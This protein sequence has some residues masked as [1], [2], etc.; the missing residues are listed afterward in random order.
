MKKWNLLYKDTYSSLDDIFA[1]LLANRGL[2]KKTEIESFLFP[3]LSKITQKSVGIDLDQLQI[4]VKRIKKAIKSNEKIIVYGDY[5]VDGITG[6]AILW[7]SL[8]KNYKNVF[9]YI[10]DRFGEGYGLSRK[11]IDHLLTKY[12][13]TKIIVT[14]DNGIVAYEAAKYA[15]ELGIDVIITDHHVAGDQKLECYALVH[16]TRLCGAAVGYMLALALEEKDSIDSDQFLDLVT[17][18]T[19]ADLVPLTGANRALVKAG[20]PVLANTKRPGLQALFSVASISREKFGIYEIGH[21]I[22]PRLN[23]AGRLFSA[24]DSLRLVCTKDFSKASLLAANLDKTN[25]ERQVLTEQ[26]TTQAQVLS[27][28]LNGSRIVFVSHEEFNEGV[29]GLVASR[30]VE[31]YYRPSFVIS[32]GEK[33]SKGS[34]RSVSGVNIIEMIR[35]VSHTLVQAGGHPMAAGFTVETA[36]LAEFKEALHKHALDVILE[37]QLQR[38]YSIDLELQFRD[39][40]VEL[41]EK[42]QLLAPFGMKNSEPV[43]MSKGVTIED[44]RFVGKNSDHVKLMLSQTGKGDHIHKL[45]CIAFGMGQK[46]RDMV[47]GNTLDIIYSIDRDEWQGR[48]RMQLKI[49]DIKIEH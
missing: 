13:D 7:E 39:I 22:A 47:P 45:G 3:D 49:K 14:V 34:A 33:I 30:L 9:P 4:A 5:D 24:M 43:F 35:S 37:E 2:T 48:K 16:T 18:A 19:V 10:P 36:R 40:N 11:G 29:I 17:L 41:Y 21:L 1:I 6:T 23:A 26:F 15:K 12:P 42:I 44:L 20:L 25:R 38:N 46:M 27:G 31:K 28:D 32:M 8:Y